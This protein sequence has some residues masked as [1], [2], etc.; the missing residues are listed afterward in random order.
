MNRREEIKQAIYDALVGKT[1]VG[2]SV[3]VSRVR[4][5]GLEEFP[6]I[7][8]YVPKETVEKQSVCDDHYLISA[9]VQIDILTELVE[10]FE[11]QLDGICSR[12]EDLLLSRD[13]RTWIPYA[14]D[15][16]YQD[17]EVFLYG[18]DN[19]QTTAVA[20]MSFLLSYNAVAF[21]GD[22]TDPDYPAEPGDLLTV[23]L[24]NHI[25]G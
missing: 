25:E 9:I 13:P 2:A 10:D 8:I 19:R 1:D 17:T 16:T 21:N 11:R 7:T 4:R 12:V 14:E 24:E 5:F 18:S 15:F 3:Y 6:N 20:T 23:E 22:T